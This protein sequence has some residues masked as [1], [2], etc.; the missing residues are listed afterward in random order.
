MSHTDSRG[1]DADNMQLSQ[2]RAQS[3]VDYLI[4][5]GIDPARLS[6]KGYGESMPK[7]VIK[8]INEQYPF[9]REGATLTESYINSLPTVEQQEIAHQL[10]RRTEFRVLRTDFKPSNN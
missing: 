6:A 2:K 3:V 7:E 1:S 4:L 10:N 8:R 5:K 9:L